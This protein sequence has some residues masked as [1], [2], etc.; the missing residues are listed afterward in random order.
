ML[1]TFVIGL[2]DGVEAALIVGIIA[3]FL[4]KNGESR[5]LRQMWWGVGAAI[6]LSAGLAVGLHLAGRA[7]SFR[8]REIMEGALAIVAAG[9]I[10]FMIVWM[11]RNAP[12]RTR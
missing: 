8:A 10:T 2:R 7:L 5:S 1:T 6:A 3:A 4:V 12:A 9:G 11:R